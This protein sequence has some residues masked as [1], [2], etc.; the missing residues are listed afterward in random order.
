MNIKKTPYVIKLFR[1]VQHANYSFLLT[2]QFQKYI[3]N[4][5]D[6]SAIDN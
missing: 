3:E 6:R 1:E 2:K 4:L 5:P